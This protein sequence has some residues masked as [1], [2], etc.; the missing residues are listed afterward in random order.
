MNTRRHATTILMAAA[1]LT[2]TLCAVAA[3]AEFVAVAHPEARSGRKR[4]SVLVAT[5]E[6]AQARGGQRRATGT[7]PAAARKQEPNA[8]YIRPAW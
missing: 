2:A 5:V 7:H 8:D 3:G 1:L 4:R 6:K